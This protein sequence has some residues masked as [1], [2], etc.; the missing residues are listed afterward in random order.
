MI[1]AKPMISAIIDATYWHVKLFLLDQ[2]I[3]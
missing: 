1:S 3:K 2:G